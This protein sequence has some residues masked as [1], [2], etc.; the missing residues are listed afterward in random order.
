MEW[1]GDKEK[2]VR[3]GLLGSLEVRSGAGREIEVPGA[4]LRT[5]LAVLLTDANNPV[6]RDRLVDAIWGSRPPRSSDHGLDVLVS[7]LR[8]LLAPEEGRLV[9]QPGGYSLRVAREELDV[10]CFED[11]LA[12]ARAASGEGRISEAVAAWRRGLGEWRGPAYGELAVVPFVVE[13]AMRLDELRSV[14]LEELFEC[15]LRLGRHRAVEPEIDG[16]VRAHPLRERA[17]ATLMLALYRSGR[18]ADALEAYRQGA[19]RL[20]EQGLEPGVALRRLQVAILRHDAALDDDTSVPAKHRRR[21][22]TRYALNDGVALAYQV[23]GNGPFDL[24]YAP[25]FITNVELVWDVPTWAAL[26]RR[27]GAFSRLI[28]FDKRGTGMSDRG[29]IVPLEVVAEDMGAVMDAAGSAEAAVIGASDAGATAI[30]F[31]ALHPGRV[32]ALILWGANARVRWA[33]D[34][35]WG[36]SDDELMTTDDRIWM[37]PGYAEQAARALGAADVEELAAMWR[38]SATPA[39]VRALQEQAQ[40]IDVRNLLPSIRVPTLVL[41]RDGDDAGAAGSDFLAAHITDA[42]H[43]TLPGSEH[44]MFGASYDYEALASEIERFLQQAW[45]RRAGYPTPSGA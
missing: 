14:T 29:E 31:A 20:A 11:A 37:E 8:S 42:K 26:L 15:E 40:S 35:P 32:W 7:H 13:E 23:S 12:H 45:L 3:F 30:Q 27:F 2:R 34:Y 44:V 18:Q 17:R 6:S 5:L 39:G 33:P 9:T 1:Q 43:V 25:P 16:F 24:V 38:Q 41:N 19:S 36:A 21:P 10:L 4:K 28:R 22:I